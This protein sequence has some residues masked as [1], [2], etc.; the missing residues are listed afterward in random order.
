MPGPGSPPGRDRDQPPVCGAAA[1]G[2]PH[3]PARGHTASRARAASRAPPSPTASPRARAC[4][5]A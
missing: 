1:V 5:R 3:P 4:W 2:S